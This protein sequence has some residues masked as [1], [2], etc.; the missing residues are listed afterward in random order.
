MMLANLL[1]KTFNLPRW[2]HAALAALSILWFQ[3][4]NVKITASYAASQHPV[5]Y[6]TGQTSFN[7]QTIKGYYAAMTDTQTL[8]VYV[9]TQI[10]DTGVIIGFACLGL[11]ACTLIARL[12]RAGSFGRKAGLLGGMSYIFG[13][14]SDA[15]ENGFS[16][17][18]LS[19][20]AGFADWLA[21]PYSLFASIK[22]GFVTLAMALAI[23]SL[24]L[25]TLGRAMKKPVFG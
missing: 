3:W 25:A 7:A 17:I 10:I 8:D 24:I 2:A 16:F 14:V 20:P 18:M 22:F 15:T 19:N 13:A 9:T 23:I 1:K 21:I 12:S 6:F 5:D 4:I 11:F